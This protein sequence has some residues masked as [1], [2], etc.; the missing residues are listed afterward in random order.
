MSEGVDL[1]SFLGYPWQGVEHF[2]ETGR[3]WGRARKRSFA[4]DGPKHYLPLDWLL[5]PQGIRRLEQI[6]LLRGE[7]RR[8]DYILTK[9]SSAGAAQN[10]RD[11]GPADQGL[12][13]PEDT[14]RSRCARARVR[15]IIA[16]LHF[17]NFDLG[18]TC[19]AF[20]K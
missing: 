1:V 5:A 20:N 15:N 10:G 3:S 12:C 18:P 7:R 16:S 9:R 19:C 6:E 4:R 17:L 2:L 11:G 14:P 8:D 13:R